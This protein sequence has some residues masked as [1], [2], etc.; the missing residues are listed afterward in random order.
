MDSL[1]ELP[2]WADIK[3]IVLH[4]LHAEDRLEAVLVCKEF[5]ETICHLERN[6][7]L[8]LNQQLIHSVKLFTIFVY[9]SLMTISSHR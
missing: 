2:G 9:R 4:H 3:E 8:V 1:L 6:K 5:Y 7:L